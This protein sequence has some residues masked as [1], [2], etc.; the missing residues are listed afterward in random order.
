MN[1][2]IYV[3][4]VATALMGFGGNAS[5]QQYPIVDDIAHK[6][7]QKY[8]NASCEQ[9]WQQHGQPKSPREQ[10]AIQAMRNDPQMRAAFIDKVAAP[11]ANKMFECGLLP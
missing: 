8:R 4:A 3:L 10:E 7:V 6:V 1:K 2:R 11:I 5:A 9:L